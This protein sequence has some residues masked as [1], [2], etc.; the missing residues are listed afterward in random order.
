MS[1]ESISALNT[2]ELRYR[3]LFET[4]QEGFLIIDFL[5][6]QIQDANPYLLDLLDYS[7]NRARS[8]SISVV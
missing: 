5:S 8:D 6:G 4:A 1:R 7:K 2:S 3:R